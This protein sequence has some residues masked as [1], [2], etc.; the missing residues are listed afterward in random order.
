MKT[1]QSIDRSKF[2]EV[3]SVVSNGL[4]KKP[5]VRAFTCIFFEQGYATAY[6]DVVAVSSPCELEILRGGLDG[7]TLSK[8]IAATGA[9]E[10]T[11]D[12]SKPDGTVLIGSH[13]DNQK[14]PGK[15]GL[16]T[17]IC[18]FAEFR[19]QRP[20]DDEIQGVVVLPEGFTD[21][22]RATSLAMGYDPSFPW[23]LGITVAFEPEGLLLYASDDH[24]IVTCSLP[25]EVDPGLHGQATILPPRFCEI[26]G[27]ICEKRKG[28]GLMVG[29]G[30]VEIECEDATAVF[31]RTLSDASPQR[32]EDIVAE[33]DWDAAVEVPEGFVACLERCEVVLGDREKCRVWVDGDLWFEANGA[34]GHV[35]DCISMEKKNTHPDVDPVEFDT[36]LL[37]RGLRAYN[38]SDYRFLIVPNKSCIVLNVEDFFF[39]LSAKAV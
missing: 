31:S 1:S 11:F 7:A 20:A 23:R 22:V 19:F 26:V 35:Q 9:K 32:F 37:R 33:V 38:R 27:S 21:V 29:P 5:L 16:R 6:D 3:L 24:T 30:W 25:A 18:D 10:V 17:P 8:Y 39:M 4:S 28:A 36:K 2:A 12:S 13:F 14:K 34:L 15:S